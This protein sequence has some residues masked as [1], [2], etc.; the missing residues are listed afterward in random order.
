MPSPPQRS[1]PAS[2]S[3]WLKSSW[4]PSATRQA[5]YL[6]VGSSS[7][8]RSVLT[9]LT[10]RVCQHTNSPCCA[11][12]LWRKSSSSGSMS[13][14]VCNYP[15]PRHTPAPISPSGHRCRTPDLSWCRAKWWPGSR[16]YLWVAGL[17]HLQSTFFGC[18]LANASAKSI[19]V[20]IR[21]IIGRSI[22]VDYK[23]NN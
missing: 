12:F 8:V 3:R 14:R 2:S 20:W 18:R 23:F 16:A 13:R 7:C 21:E 5:N 4:A 15:P 22:L 17:W 11:I 6:A 10:R 9:H 1:L 19:V